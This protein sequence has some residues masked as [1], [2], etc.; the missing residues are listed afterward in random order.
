MTDTAT[1]TDAHRKRLRQAG[2]KLGTATER[3]SAI[4]E[5]CRQ[6]AVE[7]YAAG[8]TETELAILLNVDRARTIRRWLGKMTD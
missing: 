2:K 4:V 8:M 6:L 5:E 3:R 1:I 7:M